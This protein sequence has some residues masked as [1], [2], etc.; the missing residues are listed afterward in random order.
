[1]RHLFYYLFGL[2]RLK[3]SWEI[4]LFPLKN[5]LICWGTPKKSP[6]LPETTGGGGRGYLRQ[7]GAGG[8]WKECSSI[9][10]CSSLWTMPFMNLSFQNG[11]VNLV[12][13]ILP[14]IG[15]QSNNW[16]TVII[17]ILQLRFTIYSQSYINND[18]RNIKIAKN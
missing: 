13:I 14:N 16:W 9:A 18:A 8:C 11:R 5:V 2:C 15:G 7:G 3:D 17:Y 6:E 4:Q 1:M 12:S 10:H